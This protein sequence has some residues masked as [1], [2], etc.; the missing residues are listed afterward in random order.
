ML[1]EKHDLT[2]KQEVGFILCFTFNDPIL[3]ISNLNWKST[4]ANT[5]YMYMYTNSMTLLFF[6]P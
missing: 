3:H 4:I 2:K 1:Q 5:M 6:V